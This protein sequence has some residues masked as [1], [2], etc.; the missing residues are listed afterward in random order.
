MHHGSRP[1]FACETF[2]QRKTPAFVSISFPPKKAKPRDRW[3]IPVQFGTSG[4]VTRNP[5]RLFTG[6]Q[7]I[8]G[9]QNN[10]FAQ[11][12]LTSNNFWDTWRATRSTTV[13]AF[14][15]ETP[16]DTSGRTRRSTRLI[17]RWWKENGRSTHLFFTIGANPGTA[18]FHVIL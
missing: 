8:F 1:S 17:G 10:A 12:I 13:Y 3:W 11:Q 16:E 6:V 7:F 14:R 2:D 5:T 4:P 18:L 15:A 9:L